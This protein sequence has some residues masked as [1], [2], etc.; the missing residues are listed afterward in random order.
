MKPIN[1]DNSESPPWLRAQDLLT[2]SAP[3]RFTR[4]IGERLM[5]AYPAS[6]PSHLVAD[7]LIRDVPDAVLAAID[8]KTKRIGL[9]RSK[10]LR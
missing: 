9:S 10:Y 2:E 8:A 4:C 1:V 5:G 6:V 3:N 7:I